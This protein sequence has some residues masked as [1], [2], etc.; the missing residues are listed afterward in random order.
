M[1]GWPL[2]RKALDTFPLR[3]LLQFAS[4]V[5]AAGLLG[6]GPDA[7]PAAGPCDGKNRPAFRLILTAGGAPLP[8]DLELRVRYGGGSEEYSLSDPDST[9]RVVFC[10]PATADGGSAPQNTSSGSDAGADAGAT[11]VP[12]STIE[13]LACELWTS[14][15]AT[16][17]VEASGYQTIETRLEAEIDTACDDIVTKNVPLDLAGSDAGV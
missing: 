17:I 12:P 2:S 13:A 4:V 10:A 5:L 1:E 9:P 8:G 11:P 7:A 15:A 14:G 3:S 16:V 6:C